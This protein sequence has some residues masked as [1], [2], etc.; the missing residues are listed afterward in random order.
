VLRAVRE[1]TDAPVAVGGGGFSV[2][3]RSFMADIGGD[4]G[5]VGEGERAIVEIAAAVAQGGGLPDGLRG[6]ILRPEAAADLDALRCDRTVADQAFYLREGGSATLQTKRGCNLGCSYCTYPLIE[7]RTVRMRS[8]D[9]VVEEMQRLQA[10]TGASDFTLVDA[11]FNN[12]E[13][14]ALAFCEALLKKELRVRWTG[15]FRPAV[16]DPGLFDLL[17][18]SGCSGVDAT[19]DSL[20]ETTLASLG[21]GLSPGEVEA[22]CRSASEKGLAVNLNVIFGAPGESDATLKETFDRVEACRPRS[23][24]AGIGVRL[25][26]DARLTET[27]R[28]S[29]ELQGGPVGIDPV[30]YLSEAVSET[31]VD[32][33]R[34]T[35]ARDRRFIVPALGIR[36]NPRFLSRLRRHGKRGPI[37][38]LV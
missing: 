16:D 9:L 5:V 2:A 3:P 7:G 36:Y 15:Y 17:R 38:T 26:P 10:D 30:F 28:R 13:S 14:H 6:A 4:V 37:W 29:G 21:K 31:L 34:E 24:I 12:P 20:S 18:R 33:L 23:V 8:V 32:R 1:A 11:I 22:F 25:Y 19:P 27:L 35:A